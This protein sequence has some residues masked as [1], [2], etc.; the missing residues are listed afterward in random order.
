MNIGIWMCIY[1]HHSNETH[2]VVTHIVLTWIHIFPMHSL[3]KYCRPWSQAFHQ[4]ILLAKVQFLISTNLLVIMLVTYITLIKKLIPS[5]CWEVF[6]Y[7]KAIHLW[8]YSFLPQPWHYTT[9]K[10]F[11]LQCSLVLCYT[12]VRCCW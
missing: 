5:A 2:N 12:N 3:P 7:R 6:L 10:S 4:P 11:S 9:L 1:T 8:Y